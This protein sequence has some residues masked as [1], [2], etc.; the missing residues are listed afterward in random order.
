VIAKYAKPAAAAAISCDPPY[1]ASTG[2]TATKRAG[3]D[4]AV[5]YASEAEHRALAEVLHATPAAVL[6]SGYPSAL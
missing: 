5:E 2:S 4:Y 6:L 3:L 1:L